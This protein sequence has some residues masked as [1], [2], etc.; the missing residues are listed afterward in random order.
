MR[1]RRCNLLQIEPW[2]IWWQTSREFCAPKQPTD[3]KSK[4]K[5]GIFF[6][7][8]GCD[9]CSIHA[10]T[11]RKSQKLLKWW[12]SRH[13]LCQQMR[14]KPCQLC[15]INRG[16]KEP[17]AHGRFPYKHQY[18]YPRELSTL[19]ND[20]FI[21]AIPILHV[22]YKRVLQSWLSEKQQVLNQDTIYISMMD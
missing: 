4:A 17:R 21:H 3:W 15:T 22:Q 5:K 8:S 16:F 9:K 7:M 13:T 11:T 6:L 10:A 1:L 2:Y 19:T 12:W 20:R 14:S 18:N